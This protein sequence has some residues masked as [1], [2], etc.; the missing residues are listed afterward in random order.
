[1]L[2]HPIKAIIEVTKST[3][4]L[5][6]CIF[7]LLKRGFGGYAPPKLADS[8]HIGMGNDPN[9]GGI[10]QNGQIARHVLQ[11]D[12]GSQFA[13]EQ[14]VS[15]LLRAS[16][17]GIPP[18]E[19]Q[20]WTTLILATG[21][22][23]GVQALFGRTLNDVGDHDAVVDS[24]Q[25]CRCAE[26]IRLHELD[27]LSAK[28]VCRKLS[29]SP[30]AFKSQKRAALRRFAACLQHRLMREFGAAQSH[31]S[32]ALSAH[33]ARADALIAS[34][35][36]REASTTLARLFPSI[37]RPEDVLAAII[38]SAIAHIRAGD[39]GQ[40][41]RAHLR[42]ANSLLQ[43]ADAGDRDHY[44]AGIDLVEVHLAAA[45]N[46]WSRMTG[47]AARIRAYADMNP[48]PPVLETYCRALAEV[49]DA[50]L[51]RGAKLCDV[52]AAIR[53][54]EAALER[55]H[56]PSPKLRG[57]A[58]AL[59]ADFHIRY[60]N[61][62]ALGRSEGLAS[63]KLAS[64]NAHA[65]ISWKALYTLVDNH[66]GALNLP[67]VHQ[68]AMDFFEAATDAG[69]QRATVQSA[70]L[71]AAVMAQAGRSTEA[72]T[73]IEG[74]RSVSTP[75]LC[76][77]CDLAATHAL[78]RRGDCKSAL[79]F[80]ESGL[81]RAIAFQLNELAVV[82]HL[83]R[84]TAQESLGDLS[85][86]FE[87]IEAALGILESAPSTYYQEVAAWSMARF[88]RGVKNERAGRTPF[89]V[90]IPPGTEARFFEQLSNISIPLYPVILTPRQREVAGLA[91]LG[92][93]NRQIGVELRISERTVAHHLEA[94]FTQLGIRARW[95]L[96][97]ALE[98][99][100]VTHRANDKHFP[101]PI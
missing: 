72:L 34:G 38:P 78:L 14:Q 56:N 4:V 58:L 61:E 70:L 65:D 82:A 77:M 54:L 74:C 96:G 80:V 40:A 39:L 87:S 5:F 79:P 31:V 8:E 89:D 12:E 53:E 62:V 15:E 37:R 91:R 55:L 43:V 71:L 25:P 59:R 93:T 84:K 33:L 57:T 13:T 9:A 18:A 75:T 22:L 52:S 64:E 23:K 42:A 68:Y 100:A 67:T 10:L 3:T 16:V 2:E 60:K 28:R 11:I 20:I 36:F 69:D 76:T 35:A 7:V 48:A 24:A 73:I 17:A 26:I 92:R 29:L 83:Y 47:A 49:A 98:R 97:E 46:D 44:K 32:L 6:R 19:N 50:Q 81:A 90:V 1:V 21:G 95:Q 101:H 99:P 51:F 85:G 27:G 94:A 30:S 45:L 63:Y 41:K 88:A 86:A 66:L